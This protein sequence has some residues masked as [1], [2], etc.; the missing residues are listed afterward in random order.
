MM[1]TFSVYDIVHKMIGSVH[2]VGDSAIDPITALCVATFVYYCL[3]VI[4]TRKDD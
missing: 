1:K 2:P 4:F 3:R